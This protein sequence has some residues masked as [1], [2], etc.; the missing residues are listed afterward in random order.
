M[1]IERIRE[2]F[3][4]ANQ[5]SQQ[6]LLQPRDLERIDDLFRAL[7]QLDSAVKPSLYWEERSKLNLARCDS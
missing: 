3:I 4:R 5:T 7:A 1:L 6:S 2:W